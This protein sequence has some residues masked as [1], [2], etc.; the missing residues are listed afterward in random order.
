MILIGIHDGHNASAALF[1][2]GKVVA[3]I[4]EERLRYQKNWT[5]YPVNAIQWVLDY[6]GVVIDQ[7][8]AVVFNG[9]HMPSDM[10][11]TELIQA[12]KL[13]WSL[14]YRLKTCLKRGF[15]G[16]YYTKKRKMVRIQNA[17]LSGF[18]PEK[19]NFIDHHRCHASASYYGWGKCDEPILVLTC[20]GAGDRICASVN[21]GKSG[22]LERVSSVP[23]TESI[24]S[25]YACIT[26]VLGFIPLEH[27]YK[28][29]GMAPYAEEKYS[30]E[31]ARIFRDHFAFDTEEGLTWSRKKGTP[32]PYYGY[33]YWR[34]KLE[35]M[36]FDAVMGGLQ[37]F[38]EEFISQW[39]KNCIEKTGIRKVAVGGGFFMNVKVN[40]VIMELNAVDDFFIFP[41]CGDEMNAI[42]ACYAYASHKAGRNAVLP[43][44][45]IYWGPLYE[46]K[47]IKSR[48]EKYH[49]KNEVV[50]ECF[51]H[52]INKKVAKLLSEGKVVARFCGREEMGAR[53]LGNRAILANPT[54]PEVITL[55]NKMIKKRDF[56]MPFASS[57]KV[58]RRHEY[59]VN[60]KNIDSPYMIL[61]FD[62]SDEGK[63]KLNAGTHPQDNSIR[64]QEVSKENNFQYWDLIN[65]F[66]E[67][68]GQGGVLN[69]SFNLHGF[70]IVHTPE[71][72]LD[73]LLD[74]GL[75]CLQLEDF[76]VYKKPDC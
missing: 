61:T 3:A 14:K 25:L 45:D 23:E 56:W 8:D 46:S 33:W 44:A 18:Q 16:R 68:T 74:S 62:T 26:T 59:I 54:D 42:G 9:N 22:Q 17:I 39:V 34:E 37:L 58:E 70:P 57:I 40:K 49:R 21:I 11:K 24:G 5:G 75:T 38:V 36:R 43:L 20:D 1:R 19:I 67:I 15:V 47:D 76:I 13:K 53:S 63:K 27:E 32:P 66:E 48:I 52:N 6:S 72:A 41:S 12:H 31:V 73:V 64:P 60:D 65:E 7:V 71:Q 51:E 28:L 10:N 35:G 29:M 69:T 55:I 30:N 2:D 50:F 4:Q